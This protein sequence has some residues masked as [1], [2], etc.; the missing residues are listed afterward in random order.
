MCG[1]VGFIDFSNKS[2]LNLLKG[3][4]DSLVH[5]GPDDSGYCFK[6]MPYGQVG[7]GHRRLS[8]L[9][10]SSHG[11]QPMSLDHI[12]IVYN[13]EVYNFKE[14]RC[15][16]EELGYLFSSDSDTEV[17]L[18]AYHN[19]GLDA[20]KYFNGMYAMAIFDE[21]DCSLIL[22]RDRLGVKPLYWYYE[23]GLFIFGSELRSFHLHPGFT[24]KICT[25][26]VSLYFEHGYIPQPNTIFENTRKLKAGQILKLDLNSSDINISEY[27]SVRDHFEKPKFEISEQEAVDET[28]KLIK[29]SCQYRMIS[30]VPVGIFLSGGY[31][32]TAVTALIQSGRTEKVKTFSIGFENKKYNEADF[33]KT[34][35][36]HLGTDHFEY[37]CTKNDILRLVPTL[38]EVWDEPISDNSTIP[39]LLVSQLA[40]SSVSVALSADGGDEVF[41]GYERYTQSLQYYNNINR[42]MPSRFLS[43]ALQCVRPE[44]IGIDNVLQ[45][46]SGRYHYLMSI[47]SSRSPQEIMRETGR[48]FKKGEIQQLLNKKTFGLNSDELHLN[49][50][51]LSPLE[52]MQIFDFNSYLPDDI[53]AKVDRATMSVGLE[54]REPLLDYHLVEF[55]ARLPLHLK[56]RNGQ[57]KYVLKQVVHR[58]VPQQI[59]DRPKKGFSVPIYD[60]LNNELRDYLEVYLDRATLEQ[61]GIL[62]SEYV[63]WLKE[64]FIAGHSYYAPK[65]WGIIVFQMWYRRWMS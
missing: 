46:F 24:K 25:S 23:N 18:K 49:F 3:M 39:T 51:S 19:W 12:T 65:L 15:R 54:G 4:T 57:K 58:Y 20:I 61:Q 13:G 6:V 17:I 2:S 64:R 50:D 44:K 5:R 40:K 28:E 11:H 9:D 38:V 41:S 63:H 14:I 7:L 22:I 55:G 35:A 52:E 29:S 42:V 16:L 48:L 27:W 8:I 43:K 30:D 32:S 37:Y 36:S 60:W 26:G 34:V 47:L 31:D 1:I 21:V 33:A 62:N 56:V 53:L 10:L 45:N 59:M